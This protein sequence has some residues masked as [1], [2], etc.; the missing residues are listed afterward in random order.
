MAA[1]DLDTILEAIVSHLAACLDT[2]TG[3]LAGLLPNV[4]QVKKGD[5][6]TPNA[7]K[8][9]VMVD[10]GGDIM[11]A[12]FGP[13]ALQIQ[14]EITIR[15]Y[16]SEILED[17]KVNEAARRLYESDNKT[18]GLLPAMRRFSGLGY[19]TAV[20]GA[21]YLS[22]LERPEFRISGGLELRVICKQIG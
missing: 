18:K 11:P 20:T 14:T 9:C 7:A 16:L 8:T 22:P 17:D 1:T 19:M 3:P 2:A 10:W 12:T 13:G 21:R 6:P 4:G 15:A 5:Y